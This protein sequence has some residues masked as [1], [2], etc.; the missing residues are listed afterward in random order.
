MAASRSSWCRRAARLGSSALGGGE[1][2]DELAAPARAR[3]P[4]R[5][6]ALVQLHQLAD[7]GEADAQAPL[8]PRQRP[9]PL[10]EQARRCQAGPLARCPCRSSTTRMTIWSPSC[11]ADSPM[12]PPAGVYRAALAR[13]LTRTC[14]SRTGSASS[15]RGRDEIETSSRWWRSST[16]GRTELDRLVDHRIRVDELPADLDQASSDARDIQQVVEE[17]GQVVDLA[18]DDV[19]GPASWSSAARHVERLDR[20]CGWPPAGCA[21]RGRAWPGTRPC[22]GLP[23]SGRARVRRRSVSS[24]KTRTTP[25]MRPPASRIGA[26]LSRIGRSVPS[27]EMSTV[28]LASPT[29]I[30]SRSTLATG[31]SVTWRVASH[32]VEDVGERAA[33]GVIVGPAAERRGR[34]VHECRPTVGVGNDDA[35]SDAGE[36][37][38]PSLDLSTEHVLGPFPGG[39]V[40]R[41]DHRQ[42][43]DAE[44]AGERGDGEAWRWP[45][46]R[47]HRTSQS[48]ERA[49]RSPPPPSR[50][51]SGGSHPSPVCPGRRGRPGWP[52][53]GRSACEASR[54]LSTRSA[55]ARPGTSGPRAFATDRGRR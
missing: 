13:R 36:G 21:A 2:H 8:R 11:A 55:S 16:R 12:R 10:R 32:D 29:T 26:A 25:V 27:A 49:G 18:A 39:D 52:P 28:W 23:P 54:S 31:S 47:S 33:G 9:L 46:S 38:L 4:G 41:D 20:R 37:H 17:V 40:T 50:R 45:G 48:V 6:A 42:G 24:R 30:P 3:A 14:S 19:L 43:G 51:W 53:R 34:G 1:P 22:S 5:D 7:D 35:V 15:R 44:E